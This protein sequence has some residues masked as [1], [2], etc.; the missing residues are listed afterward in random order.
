MICLIKGIILLSCGFLI[1]MR[2]M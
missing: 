1:S 2:I